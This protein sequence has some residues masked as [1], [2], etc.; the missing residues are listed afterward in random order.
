MG[1]APLIIIRIINMNP[2]PDADLPVPVSFLLEWA[3]DFSL[4]CI[5][6]RRKG[7]PGLVVPR[8]VF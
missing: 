7:A 5:C 4:G 2:A 8:K 6:I 1:V 3:R